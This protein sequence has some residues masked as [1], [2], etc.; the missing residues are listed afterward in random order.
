MLYSVQ[1][2]RL[3]IKPDKP[4]L[5]EVPRLGVFSTLQNSKLDDQPENSTVYTVP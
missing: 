1:R 3:Q 2:Q 4:V 5:I